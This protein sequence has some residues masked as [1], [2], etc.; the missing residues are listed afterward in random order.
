M[1][2][3]SPLCSMRRR[4][5]IHPLARRPERSAQSQML[6]RDS[7]IE[8]RETR[9]FESRRT[10][11]AAGVVGYADGFLGYAEDPK[12]DLPIAVD[13]VVSNERVLSGRHR[14]QNPLGL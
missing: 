5:R 11:G 1:P 10:E 6:L 12:V 14:L 9:R 13:V 7:G 8:N 3:R 4:F 2:V